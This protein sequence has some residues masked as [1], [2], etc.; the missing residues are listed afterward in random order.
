[1]KSIVDKLKETV[2]LEE[3]KNANEMNFKAFEQFISQMDKLGYSQKP[4]YTFPLVDSIGKT[5]YL[6]LNKHS[7]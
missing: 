3:K 4:D 6:I 5:T 7:V 1:M 2:K